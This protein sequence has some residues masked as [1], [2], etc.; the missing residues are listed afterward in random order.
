MAQEYFVTVNM[1]RNTSA[2][3][4][5]SL[6]FLRHPDVLLFPVEKKFRVYLS[7]SGFFFLYHLTNKIYLV[8]MSFSIANK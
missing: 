3:R 7:A 4:C 6:C 5:N 1:L 8:N 2:S